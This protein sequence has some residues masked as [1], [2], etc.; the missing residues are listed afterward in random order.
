MSGYSKWYCIRRRTDVLVR[1][2]CIIQNNQVSFEQVL[3][4]LV[5]LL[6]FAFPDGKH[7]LMGAGGWV[8]IMTKIPLFFYFGSLFWSIERSKLT[9]SNQLH[10]Y[11]KKCSFEYFPSQFFFKSKFSISAVGQNR[12][13]RNKKTRNNFS[14]FSICHFLISFLDRFL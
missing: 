2:W 5:N 11:H 13:Y 14:E 4:H 1:N 10:K 7:L 6:M 9:S 8:F 12:K 3:K